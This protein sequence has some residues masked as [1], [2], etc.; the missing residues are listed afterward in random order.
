MGNTVKCQKINDCIDSKEVYFEI[1]D[2]KKKFIRSKFINRNEIDNKYYKKVES[3]GAN[4]NKASFLNNKV[5]N[6]SISSDN[7]KSIEESTNKNYN[8][9]KYK[10]NKRIN[11]LSNNESGDIENITNNNNSKIRKRE[12]DNG[13]IKVI[14]FNDRHIGKD[15]IPELT[16]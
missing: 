15:A 6:I 11:K 13:S 10:I 1:V 3:K 2:V 7:Y 8:I 5:T 4:T 14:L 16:D 9:D 12:Y